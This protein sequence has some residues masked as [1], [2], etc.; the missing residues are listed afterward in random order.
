MLRLIINP[1]IRFI[2]LVSILGA[3]AFVMTQGS[4][5]KARISNI[6]FETYIELAP[7]AA[8]EAIVFVDIDDQSLSRVGQWPWPRPYI[9][10]I[11][12]NIK[13]SGAAV[14]VFDG[15]IAEPDRTSPENLVSMLEEGHPARAALAGQESHDIILAQ[16]IRDV[17]NFV[18]GFSGGSQVK[19]PFI[20]RGILAKKE[21]KD[22]LFSQK[23]AGS[24]YFKYTSQFLPEL[25]KSAAGNGSF[26]ASAEGD[27]VIRRTGLIF[28]D[29]KTLYP[30]LVLEA[31]RLYENEGKDF[32]KVAATQGYEN[33]KMQSPL[34]TSVGQ[35]NIP[36][37]AEGK[38]WVYFRDFDKEREYIPAYQFLNAH[39]NEQYEGAAKPD[40]TG[41]VVFIASSAEGLMDLRAT[42]LGMKPGV[43]IHMNAFEQILQQK[44]LVRPYAANVL[45]I[46]GAIVAALVL[47]GLSFFI[48]PVLQV[49]F[50]TLLSVSIFGGAWYAFTA[51]G[52]L[53]DPV[54]PVFLI[55]SM[56]FVSAMLSFLKTEYE[57][58]QVSDAFGH[59]ISPDFMRELT[60]NPD[61]LKLGG[62]IRDLTVMFT[63]IRSF[64]TI[65][66]GLTPEELI[67]LMNDFLTP[68]SDLVM[69]NRGTIDKYMG[70]AMMAF[71]NAPL[72][73]ADHARHAC[74][75][76]LG[77]QAALAPINDGVKARAQ[78]QG[79]DPVL[80]K[81]GIGINTGPCA[82][83]NMGSRQRFAYSALGDAVNMASRFEGQTKHYGVGILIG[84]DSYKHVQDFAV[85]EADLVKVQGKSIPA[86]IY[87]L[88]GDQDM[89]VQP[90]FQALKVKHE[91]MLSAYRAR[92]FEQAKALAQEAKDM[93]VGGLD[94]LY[95]V[96]VTRAED[97]IQMPP[98]DAWDGVFEAVSK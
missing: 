77:M 40:L 91:A 97:L 92:G 73:D 79:R 95:H 26:M 20:K 52:G 64:T 83:G 27:A 9:A 80:L 7:R 55:V 23:G 25:Q 60:K 54:T 82:V 16:A 6:V 57:K 50:T 69:Q 70:D 5:L 66:E 56:S 10:E 4:D 12:R 42:P 31:L 18:T 34:V 75:T 37:D 63:D 53:F 71:W 15:V 41:K 2:F 76:A 11:I 46:G 85:L 67:Q 94:G 22:F 44:F 78:K 89:A 29:G 86:R 62:E 87:V 51:F 72:D 65:S 93:G 81:A 21:I 98:G 96:Y 59:Y 84:E 45:E 61:K 90:G 68:M 58:H 35:Y 36:T 17:G 33:Y 13:Q 43:H 19:P 74:Q 38:M 3:F 30:S 39:Y 24:T 47:I 32:I 49:L 88:L 8:S 1:Y 48:G 14:I 28:H